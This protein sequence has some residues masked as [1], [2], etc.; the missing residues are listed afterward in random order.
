MSDVPVLAVHGIG[1]LQ[2]D[3]EP[4]PAARVLADEWRKSLAEGYAACRLTHLTVPD[5]AVAYYAHHL[6]PDERQDHADTADLD[7]LSPEERQIAWEFLH[8]AGA[9]LP[10]E[11]QGWALAPLRQALHWVANDRRRPAEILARVVV[12]LA[13]EVYSYMSSPER[14][15]RAR[16][17]VIDAVRAHRPRVVLA[18][19]LGSVVTYEALHEAADLSVDLLV[20]LGSPL[21]LPGAVFDALDPAPLDGRGTRPPGVDH[22]YNMAD[23]GDLV[24][25]PKELGGRFPVDRHGTTSIGL[26]DFHTLG[27]YLREGTAVAGMAP[28]VS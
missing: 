21:G 12:A 9:P 5:L 1:N 2:Q 14:R 18:H 17:T 26:V 23:P 20:T 22:W 24:A 25:L 27:G 15:W 7:Q 19:S 11:E 13:R 28:Y 10:R 4:G 16:A 8:G 3:L 6:S